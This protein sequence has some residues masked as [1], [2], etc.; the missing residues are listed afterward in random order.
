M[1]RFRTIATQRHRKTGALLQIILEFPADLADEL[2][3]YCKRHGVDESE[4]IEHA[5]DAFLGT[6]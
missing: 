5:L 1:K 3:D 2:K 4:V 6:T